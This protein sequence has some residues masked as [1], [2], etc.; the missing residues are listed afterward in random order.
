M[1]KASKA[2]SGLLRL[3]SGGKNSFVRPQRRAGPVPC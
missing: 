3:Q 2:R 1:T